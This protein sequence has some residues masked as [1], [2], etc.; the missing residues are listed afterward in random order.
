MYAG[1]D[2]TLHLAEKC[3]DPIRVVPRALLS[4]V[5]IG[6]LTAFGF[7]IAMCYSID[8]LSSLLDTM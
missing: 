5:L 2:G 1:I 8:D 6:F 7:A 3:T 4:T